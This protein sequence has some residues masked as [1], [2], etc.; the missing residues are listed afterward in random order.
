ML[1]PFRFG[2]IPSAAK[3]ACCCSF[4]GRA[5]ALPF[6]VLRTA[7]DSS[8]VRALRDGAALPLAQVSF[9]NLGHPVCGCRCVFVF[10]WCC[11]GLRGKQVLRLHFVWLRMT[12][13]VRMSFTLRSFGGFVAGRDLTFRYV[14]P[15]GILRCAQ[16]DGLWPLELRWV[17][18]RSWRLREISGLRYPSSASSKAFQFPFCGVLL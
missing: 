15:V 6:R 18:W 3:T 4:Y 5:E 7:F 13:F 14:K 17:W 8:R 10:L 12:N 1:R 11:S 9:A 16:N 2:C